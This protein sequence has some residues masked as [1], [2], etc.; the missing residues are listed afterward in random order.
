MQDL[1]RVGELSTATK[2]KPVASLP[3]AG[4]LNLFS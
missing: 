2:A 1:I 4:D 3:V